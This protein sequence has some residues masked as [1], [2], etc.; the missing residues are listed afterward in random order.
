MIFTLRV[1]KCNEIYVYVIVSSLQEITTAFSRCMFRDNQE[2]RWIAPTGVV[3][4]ASINFRS[5]T[6]VFS[7]PPNGIT[8]I[9]SGDDMPIYEHIVAW[10]MGNVSIKKIRHTSRVIQITCV[11]FSTTVSN[12]D[13][14]EKNILNVQIHVHKW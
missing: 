11:I 7:V 1:T 8:K 4:F 2:Q 12:I 3:D 13:L 6:S 14:F 9:Y 10:N 5:L